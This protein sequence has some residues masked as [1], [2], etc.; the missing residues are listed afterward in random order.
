MNRNKNQMNG[1]VNARGGRVTSRRLVVA[2]THDQS[3]PD[4]KTKQNIAAAAV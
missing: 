1:A 3:K 4:R 2:I